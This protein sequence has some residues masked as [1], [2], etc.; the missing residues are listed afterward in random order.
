MRQAARRLAPEDRQRRHKLTEAAKLFLSIGT[1]FFSLRAAN[2]FREA[3]AHDKAADLFSQ[4]GKWQEA[5]QQWQLCKAWAPA[6][7]AWAQAGEG[8]V[9]TALRACRKVRRVMPCASYAYQ[10]CSFTIAS[11]QSS[12][13]G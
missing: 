12:R 13:I 3:G 7:H 9:R 5:A 1:P 4:L 8:Y 11:C 10:A 6:A 2:C